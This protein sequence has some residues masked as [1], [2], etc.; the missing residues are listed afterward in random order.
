MK[1]R[2]II[3]LL[4][5]LVTNSF[6]QSNFRF[7]WDYAR[8]NYDDSSSYLE[9][10]Y[11]FYQPD[12]KIVS[13]DSSKF[14]QGAFRIILTQENNLDVLMNKEYQFKSII[15]EDNS[16]QSKSLIGNL[17][18]VIQPGKYL[19]TLIGRD[20]NNNAS[21]DS[22]KFSLQIFPKVKEKISIS[23][24]QLA[25]SIV[26]SEQTNSVFYKNSYEVVPNPTFIYGQNCPVLY[27][28]TEI[29]NVMS[30][31]KSELLKVEQILFNSN[32]I[33]VIKKSRFISRKKPDVVEAGALNV[34]KIPSGT[35]TLIIAVS[36]SLLNSSTLTSRKIYI[37]NPGIIDTMQ[38][39][40][41][42]NDVLSSEYG[43]MEE[44]EL[45]ESYAVSKY[46]ATSQEVDK[47][48]KLKDVEGKRNFLF[49]F[50]KKRDEIAFTPQNEFKMEYLKRVDYTNAKFST[51]TKKGWRSDRG[52]VYIM[53][54]EPSEIERFPNQVD[55]KPY[56]IWHYNSLEGGVI[57]VFA[58]IT[59]FSDYT[60]IHS[61]LR[62]E[63]RDDDWTRRIAT[64]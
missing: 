54:G 31:A 24:I 48:S 35:Y 28:Y 33:S 17:G 19:C 6:T 14:I 3:I 36:D 30:N 53:Y 27:F 59:G 22:V 38:Q 21:I 20:I 32:N 49:E 55:T 42:Q 60:L 58:D 50:W 26:Q 8:F 45:N 46:I 40:A 1:T 13:D 11:S 44:D 62:G 15:I 34:S 51:I 18:F 12:F 7:D 43:S 39:Q 61:T 25:S 5:Y 29:Y 4:I 64:N 57:F 37:Y 9:I 23:D 56:E 16:N 63:L 2:L 10:Y 52:R 41:V 47:W